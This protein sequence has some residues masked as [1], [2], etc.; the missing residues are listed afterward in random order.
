MMKY[1][2][3]NQTEF[4]ASGSRWLI[5]HYQKVVMLQTQAGRAGGSLPGAGQ[6]AWFW[7][8][9]IHLWLLLNIPLWSVGKTGVPPHR[10]PRA[11]KEPQPKGSWSIREKRLRQSGLL[12]F[13]WAKCPVNHQPIASHRQ[14]VL[15]VAA[16]ANV[17][18]FLVPYTDLILLHQREA[19]EPTCS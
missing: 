7:E 13:A 3:G 5:G 19:N 16:Q 10:G 15:S 14:A 6:I 9:N 8:R 18:S 17:S 11:I 12:S 4:T 2:G 1:P